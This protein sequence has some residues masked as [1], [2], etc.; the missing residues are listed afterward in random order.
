MTLECYPI[1]LAKIEHVLLLLIKA[2]SRSST[3]LLIAC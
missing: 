2:A 3:I 1:D